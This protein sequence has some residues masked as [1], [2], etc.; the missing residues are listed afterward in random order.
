MN[1][2]L[3]NNGIFIL[4]KNNILFTTHSNDKDYT[5]LIIIINRL[6][7]IFQNDNEINVEKLFLFT[8]NIIYKEKSFITLLFE[9]KNKN[10]FILYFFSLN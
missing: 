10:L 7:Q 4:D 8:N 2:C 5:N 3:E 9:L 6:I 1:I